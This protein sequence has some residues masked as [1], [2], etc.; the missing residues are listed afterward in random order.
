MENESLKPVVTGEKRVV[1]MG[2]SITEYWEDEDPAFFK[3][4]PYINRGIK[5][6]TTAQMLV[7]FRQDVTDLNPAVVVILGGI[8]D[9]AQNNGPVTLKNIMD[10]II[11][12]VELAKQHHVQVVLCSVLPANSFSLKNDPQPAE[13]IIELNKMIRSYAQNN[14]IAYV[15][16]YPALVDDKK[17]LDK[18]YT[19]DE[20]HPV[21]AGYKVMEPLLQA[22]IDAALKQLP[23]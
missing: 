19:A 8:N 2:D 23:G 4:R 15:D 11:S 17:G 9:I 12:M 3:D 14:N 16:Y 21:L 1:F 10:N 7:R 5:S 18:K 6:Q 20:I 22:G 13:R